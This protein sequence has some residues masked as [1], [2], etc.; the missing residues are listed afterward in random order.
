M[1][2]AI[3]KKRLLVETLIAM[4]FLIAA[5]VF[6]QR[7]NLQGELEL[8]LQ[9]KIS[10]GERDTIRLFIGKEAPQE[11]RV[12]SSNTIQEIRFPLP[13]R[14]IQNLRIGLGMNPGFVAIKRITLSGLFKDYSLE[15][16][17]LQKLFNRH[18]QLDQQEFKWGLFYIT[19]TA[20]DNWIAPGNA[21]YPI[22]YK[23]QTDKTIH[24]LVAP[25]LALLFFYFLHFLSFKNL[26]IFFSRKIYANGVLIILVLLYLPL[27]QNIIGVNSKS[28]LVEKR[29]MNR[30]PE[31]RFD[32]IFQFSKG[33]TP[34]YNDTFP[35]RDSLIYMN[36]RIKITLFGI[37]PV[38]SVFIGK[39]GWL[40]MDKK[41]NDP[42]TIDCFR[43]ISPFNQ[44]ELA[45]W[46]KVLE[47]RYY[48]LT[49]RGIH[50]L[51]IIAPNKNT[52]YPEFMPDHIHKVHKQSRMDQL[53][54]YL[55]AH[56]NVP[57]L[58]TRPVLI[59]AKK[60]YKVYSQT[61]THWNDYGAF[62]VNGE[63]INYIKRFP[64]FK[65]ARPL[66]ITDF[67]IKMVNR[68]GGDLAEKLALQKEVLREE[69]IIINPLFKQKFDGDKMDRLSRFVRQGYT[70]NKE[71]TLPNIL[72]VHDS[73]YKKLKPFLS[74]QFSRIVYIWDWDMNFYPS[75]IERE[76]PKLVIDE[77]AE[78][79]LMQSPPAAKTIFE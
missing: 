38:K 71:A 19:S 47:Q 25:I 50:Y 48:Y 24:Y 10:R 55:K 77:M 31:L 46:R 66:P 8:V 70:E 29:T 21:F 6:I 60:N 3:N 12:N 39:E 14:K 43:S 64:A 52:I 58:D 22:L 73:F 9:A 18:H 76:K 13:K 61:D 30:K 57:V 33:F 40:F 4:L 53:L 74:A 20:P 44:N 34:Y 16:R 62:N 54:N 26:G 72:M 65:D 56:S 37:S 11:I 59:A 45:Q 17:K 79:F 63:I 51:F 35:F 68:S 42:G 27:L 28:Q 7:S 15:G 23:L 2:Q 78:R 36:N 1:E 69:K 75:V 67:N 32:S 41:N 49:A 5:F